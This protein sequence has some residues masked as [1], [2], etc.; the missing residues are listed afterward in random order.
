LKEM[1]LQHKINKWQGKTHP[2]IEWK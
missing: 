1:N 2:K